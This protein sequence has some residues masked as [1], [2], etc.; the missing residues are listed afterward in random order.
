[1][2]KAKHMGISKRVVDEAKKRLNV[3]SVKYGSQ[4]F[5]TLPDELPL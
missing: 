5:W 3:Q 2:D 1:M 4:W